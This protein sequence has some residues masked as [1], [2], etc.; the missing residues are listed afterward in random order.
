MKKA[1][2]VAAAVV[3]AG[4][5]VF[6]GSQ[7]S[8]DDKNG[9]DYFSFDDRSG[10][11]EDENLDEPE[12]YEYGPTDITPDKYD[13][14]Y[15]G[16]WRI[17]GNPFSSL[18]FVRV[19]NGSFHDPVVLHGLIRSPVSGIVGDTYVSMYLSGNVMSDGVI[20]GTAGGFGAG[21]GPEIATSI[22]SSGRLGGNIVDDRMILHYDLLTQVLI[23][24]FGEM[25]YN[26]SGMMELSKLPH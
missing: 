1:V 19:S 26:N 23:P 2:L 9:A 22:K 14:M 5:G 18:V 16:F 6:V 8:N 4:G 24:G 12:D 17:S 7:I 20:Y 21:T 10:A 11:D 15:Q 13:G 3:V 25:P